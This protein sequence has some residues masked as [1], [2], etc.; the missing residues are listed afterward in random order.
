MAERK[1]KTGA[2]ERRGRG[3]SPQ[4]LL[5]ALCTLGSHAVATVSRKGLLAVYVLNES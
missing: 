2:N 5:D 1:R 3:A 4:S